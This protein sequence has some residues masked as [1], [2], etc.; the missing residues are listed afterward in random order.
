[1]GR[2]WWWA[3]GAAWAGAIVL[4]ALH[5]VAWASAPAPVTAIAW[6]VAALF[7]PG[8]LFVAIL[9]PRRIDSVGPL[10]RTLYALGA[11]YALLIAQLLL[12]SYLPG[13]LATWQVASSVM[14]LSGLLAAAAWYRNRQPTSS[15][16]YPTG[17]HPTGF[18]PTGLIPTERQR[19]GPSLWIAALGV[20][21]IAATTRIPNLGYAEFHGDE[22]RAVLR[23]AAIMQ[24]DEGVLF[25]HRKGPVE[26]LL[27][28]AQF[29]LGITTTEAAA[30]LPFLVAN[31]AALLAVVLL[32]WRVWGLC[33]GVVAA[34]LLSA[35]GYL[36]AFARFVQYQS[37]VLLMAALAVL[38][39]IEALQRARAGD[40][41]FL[42]ARLLLAATFMSTGLLAHYDAAAALIPVAALLVA[43]AS[44]RVVGWG[45]LGRAIWVPVL[46]GAAMLALYYAPALLNSNASGTLA[47]LRDERVVGAGLPVNNLGD[48]LLRG[49]LYSSAWMLATYGALLGAALA[50]TFVRGFGKMWG[51]LLLIL[52]L[53]TL[54]VVGWML[55]SN[56][57]MAG[58][59]GVMPALLAIGVTLL[60]ACIAPHQRAEE[61]AIWLW[62]TLPA[63]AMLFL[64][65]APRTHVHV[66]HTP[67]ALLAGSAASALW[68]WIGARSQDRARTL[69][70]VAISAS[71]ALFALLSLHPLLYFTSTSE[72]LRNGATLAWLY[73]R[74]LG[75]ESVDGRFGFPFVN[76]WKVVGAAYE[77]GEIA[78]AFETNQR[79]A[80]VPAWYTRGADRCSDRAQ[81]YFAGDVLEPWAEHNDAIADRLDAEGYVTW[82]NV[83][84]GESPRMKIWQQGA[85]GDAR[86]LPLDDV[87]P[88]FDAMADATLPLDY[89]IIQP[90]PAV[91]LDANF[92]GMVRLEGYTLEAPIPAQP[93]DEVRLRL[94]WRALSPMETS[95][96]VFVQ[97]YDG[98]GT[99]ALQ[100][101]SL[102]VCNQEPTTTWSPGD[103]VVDTHVMVVQDV[104]AGE[105][106]I[107]VGLYDA[108]TGVRVPRLTSGIPDIIDNVQVDTILI[109]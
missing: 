7:A 82:G 46:A 86:T 52:A 102:P 43:I 47:Y 5:H 84:V 57:L 72:A 58:N 4:L 29:A 40:A 81:Y 16:F 83:T 55:A 108:A 53:L 35:D 17:L 20:L 30:R 56:P 3:L 95:Y 9:L 97:A 67:I 91:A 21:L 66:F 34:L 92:G 1:M 76:G 8:A 74:A 65:A 68:V 73:P 12:L 100:R 31:L 2:R 99:K 71:V 24:G 22:A 23:A 25:L 11:G 39:L 77:E 13:P 32:G 70:I 18:Q 64:V 109:E 79:Y 62:L 44:T 60:L 90:K 78:G 36:V 107:Y 63:I 28:A 59:A 96:T 54:G 104:P 80:W 94:F 75:V 6:I 27:P 69:R 89:P 19:E 15:S 85:G 38:I 37:V 10:A 50:I 49:M 101:D 48:Y 105:Y 87:A 103:L 14:L 88:R 61:R 98:A 42:R 26:L 51:W 106:P 93:G 41:R 33:A 45:G